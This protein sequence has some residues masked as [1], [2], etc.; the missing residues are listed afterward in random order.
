MTQKP[1]Q[2]IE[3]AIFH[4]NDMHCHLDAMARLSTHARQ[5]REDA[6]AQGRHVF[7][8]DAGDAA[9]RRMPPMARELPG[10]RRELSATPGK[11]VT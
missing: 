2:L 8:W 3:L 4:S 11:D 10:R 7:F 5:L 6:E 9:D 1:N